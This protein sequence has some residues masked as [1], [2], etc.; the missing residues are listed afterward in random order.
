MRTYTLPVSSPPTG[1]PPMVLS[2]PSPVD[3]VMYRGDSGRFRVSV[4]TP[5][6]VPMDVSSATWL[7]EVTK[8]LSDTTVMATFDVT[9]VGGDTSS[10]DVILTPAEAANLVQSG[11]WDLQMTAGGEVQTIM[12]GK[13]IV[14]QDVSR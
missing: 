9:P 3:L 12:A 1:L 2:K 7:C 14:T 4:T 10:I 6:G 8:S 5:D 11:V 13:A